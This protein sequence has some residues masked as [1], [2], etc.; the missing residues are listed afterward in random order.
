MTAN[1]VL[2]ILAILVISSAASGGIV[3]LEVD[4]ADPNLPT[5]NYDVDPGSDITM[6]MVADADLVAIWTDI[7]GTGEVK[8]PISSNPYFNIAFDGVIQNNGT[9]LITG[10]SLSHTMEFDGHHLDAGETIYSFTYT[11]PDAPGTTVDIAGA[12]VTV[13]FLD[14]SSAT[15]LGAATLNITPEPMTIALLG[16][17]GLFLRRRRS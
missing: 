17:G 7:L 4:G 15:S 13:S 11:V 1:K 5:G 14:W 3:W 9:Q 8:A 16:F 12:N 6:I 2:I 10:I